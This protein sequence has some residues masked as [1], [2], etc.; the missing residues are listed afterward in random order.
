[1]D[2]EGGGGEKREDSVHSVWCFTMQ[3]RD[4]GSHPPS[5]SVL[6]HNM[7][8]ESY[9]GTGS[10]KGL[11]LGL[12]PY[13]DRQHYTETTVVF[14]EMS[15]QQKQL[16]LTEERRSFRKTLNVELSFIKFLNIRP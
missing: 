12:C 6:N 4:T 11:L 10:E 7:Q 16:I 13:C 5:E 3:D 8:E 9:A 15:F 14:L 1:M 2:E